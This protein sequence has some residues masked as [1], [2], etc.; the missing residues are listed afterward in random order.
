MRPSSSAPAS[1]AGN[2]T[3]PRESALNSSFMSGIHDSG[4]SRTTDITS[5][6][7]F[8]SM[9]SLRIKSGFK[10]GYF[11]P[12]HDGFVFLTRKKPSAS[13]PIMQDLVATAQNSATESGGNV[14]EL[15]EKLVKNLET[16]YTTLL[17]CDLP[18]DSAISISLQKAAE[19]IAK[20]IRDY[21]EKLGQFRDIDFDIRNGHI[22][23]TLEDTG[24]NLRQIL[25]DRALSESSA[26]I[27][28]IEFELTEVEKKIATDESA[29]T[30][31]ISQLNAKDDKSENGVTKLKAE[32]A[33]KEQYEKFKKF[34]KFSVS[35]VKSKTEILVSASETMELA[36]D[37]A[38]T[39]PPSLRTPDVS[40]FFSYQIDD[41]DGDLSTSFLIDTSRRPDVTIF[42][43]ATA[44]ATS[45]QGDHVTAYTSFLQLFVNLIPLVGKYEDLPHKAREMLSLVFNQD[46]MTSFCFITDQTVQQQPIS[47]NNR[48]EF[49]KAVGKEYD[50]IAAINLIIKTYQAE[51]SCAKICAI[52]DEYLRSMNAAPLTAVRIPAGAKNNKDKKEGKK[53]TALERLSKHFAGEI[54]I[55][56][57]DEDIKKLEPISSD[58]PSHQ[59][60][61]KRKANLEEWKKRLIPATQEPENTKLFRYGF[62]SVCNSIRDGLCDL[63]DIPSRDRLSEIGS[64]YIEYYDD[65][66]KQIIVRHFRI[67]GVMLS[68]ITNGLDDLA[69]KEKSITIYKIIADGFLEKLKSDPD[70]K[71]TV[72]RIKQSYVVGN[73]AY[74]FES[75]SPTA[76]PQ[77]TITFAEFL[78]KILEERAEKF[79]A[80]YLTFEKREF[81]FRSPPEAR[82]RSSAHDSAKDVSGVLNPLF[83]RTVAPETLSFDAELDAFNFVSDRSNLTHQNMMT[84][85]R[86]S[87]VGSGIGEADYDKMVDK[88]IAIAVIS[89]DNSID[90]S[91]RDVIL[92]FIGQEVPQDQAS[93]ALCRGHISTLGVIEGDTHWSALHLR[94]G[95][96][97]EGDAQIIHAYHMDSSGSISIP[98]AVTRVLSSIKTNVASFPASEVK[99]RASA[100]L[101]N[102]S[103]ANCRNLPCDAQTDGYSCG[104]HTAFNLLRMHNHE[105]SF[106]V[107]GAAAGNISDRVTQESASLDFDS[108][109]RS[110]KAILQQHFNPASPTFSSADPDFDS[111]KIIHS[112]MTGDG[113]FFEKLESLMRI[114]EFFQRYG[115][116]DI[117]SAELLN[118]LKIE[119]LY[120]KIIGD[121][122]E[123]IRVAA[124]TYDSPRINST[125]ELEEYLE[126]INTPSRCQ[127]PKLLLPLLRKITGNIDNFVECLNADNLSEYDALLD[128]TTI[129]TETLEAAGETLTT[130]SLG[131]DKMLNIFL[132]IGPGIEKEFVRIDTNIEALGKEKLSSVFDCRSEASYKKAIASIKEIISKNLDKDVHLITYGHGKRDRTIRLGKDVFP[133]SIFNDL[134][135]PRPFVL[136]VVSCH[137]GAGIDGLRDK[138]KESQTMIIY[139]GKRATISSS[140]TERVQEIIDSRDFVPQLIS[141]NANRSIKLTPPE[142]IKIITRDGVRKFSPFE[143][144]K[145][146]KKPSEKAILAEIIKQQIDVIGLLKPSED[147]EEAKALSSLDLDKVLRESSAEMKRYLS[148]L[149]FMVAITKE[150]TKAEYLTHLVND[151]GV[152]P[153][154]THDARNEKLSLIIETCAAGNLEM[155][156]F[157]I[158]KDAAQATLQTDSGLTPLMAACQNGKEEVVEFLLPFL[159]KEQVAQKNNDED[160]AVTLACRSG[161]SLEILQ[162]LMAKDE[163]DI[164]EIKKDG[165]NILHDAAI[166]GNVEVFEFLY[167]QLEAIAV[168]YASQ[169]N[170]NERT[171]TDEAIAKNHL[172]IVDFAIEHKLPFSET[173]LVG[174]KHLL[175]EAGL[176]G[177]NHLLDYLISHDLA[178]LG[179]AEEDSGIF[180]ILA[181]A[182][183]DQK[184]IDLAAK[185]LSKGLGVEDLNTK[186]S[187]G[188]TAIDLAHDSGNE[189]MVELFLEYSK[190]SERVVAE[191]SSAFAES[192]SQ[193]HRE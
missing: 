131:H 92:N 132:I 154:K 27:D 17:S 147:S 142:T 120:K 80:L 101:K 59:L 174:K 79:K 156:R 161:C 31:S 48:R 121:C 94:R 40:S 81:A 168:E 15:S 86:S 45:T 133:E 52:G 175:F 82:A 6:S 46:D 155:A 144:F 126:K 191:S 179:D 54:L 33:K 180:H 98:S 67:S 85:L 78:A 160:S 130:P 14:F 165:C 125:E 113:D 146:G 68:W 84:L 53:I 93:I 41:A 2:T 109:I 60:K 114:E 30:N 162:S 185:L 74:D 171:P 66:V 135:H 128:S 153:I 22:P 106:E 102:I 176:N 19:K 55:K 136:S 148:D 39:H 193:P 157:L 58:S 65:L 138:M 95:V 28:K 26:L 140:D 167:T 141:I 44:T 166:G 35:I 177:H 173:N 57:I 118:S 3:P 96:V 116:G 143:S 172:A 13:N 83:S 62:N 51:C 182:E 16:Y 25:F 18:D 134:E 72:E 61:R 90:T 107:A 112:T 119:K 42:D 152:D 89:E 123:G 122:V 145:G 10:R 190:P 103:F 49:L 178:D 151:L 181:A 12:L 100:V 111:K 21:K 75:T 169:N 99:E 38:A 170:L 43:G 7:G 50:K 159:T 1:E 110:K 11:Q 34:K 4:A 71:E 91:L 192:R 127:N 77:S 56:L 150:D 104:Y 97:G 124:Y 29:V 8:S 189:R 186:N 88:N 163:I 137:A 149:A 5:G 115:D 139:A 70:L 117:E 20:V 63:L 108:F 23:N 24:I 47:D 129:A 87:F 158:E 105:E 64:S 9:K 37:V 36:E 187:A 188:K 69:K 183:F 32:E 184:K 73:R 164:T 76:E